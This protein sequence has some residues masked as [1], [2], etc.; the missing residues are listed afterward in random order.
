MALDGRKIRFT[1]DIDDVDPE[2]LKV[3]S[4]VAHERMD[5]PYRLTLDVS[6]YATL[7]PDALLGNRATFSVEYADA[8]G[9][10]RRW[11][12]VIVEM[13]VDEVEAGSYSVQVV[14]APPME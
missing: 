4:F 9:D 13:T 12:G 5:E 11:R 2:A 14:I 3:L 10:V 8:E 6:T 1:L 7:D